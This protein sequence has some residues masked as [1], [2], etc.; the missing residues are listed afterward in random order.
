MEDPETRQHEEYNLEAIAALEGEKMVTLEML[1]EAWPNEYK[2]ILEK[3]SLEQLPAP[4]PAEPKPI[5][6]P[7]LANLMLGPF[8]ESALETG[9]TAEL[10][11]VNCAQTL[12]P[13]G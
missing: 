4:A 8:V 13:F 7:S 11:F 5:T 12:N 3:K 10:D 9:D 1:A 2:K 6:I